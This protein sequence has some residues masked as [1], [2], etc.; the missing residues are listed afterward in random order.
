[1]TIADSDGSTQGTSRT[2]SL[3][4]GDNEITVTVTAEDEATTKVY[5]ITVTRAEPDVDWG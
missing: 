4:T 5:T 3:A 1:M 2:V